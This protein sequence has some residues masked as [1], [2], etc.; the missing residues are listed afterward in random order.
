MAA[1]GNTRQQPGEVGLGLAPR[2]LERVIARV[3]AALGARNVVFD[4]KAALAAPANVSSHFRIFSIAR[5][6][7]SAAILSR[8]RSGLVTVNFDSPGTVASTTE[9]LVRPRPSC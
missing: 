4:F 8:A 3:A 9:T 5:I 1:I 6:A 2:A 7:A